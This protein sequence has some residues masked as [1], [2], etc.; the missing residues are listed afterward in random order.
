MKPHPNV[1]SPVHV[2]DV[3]VEVEIEASP[4]VVWKALTADIGRWW[5]E[6]FYCGGGSA[7]GRMLLEESPGGRL[8]EDHG[9]GDGLLWGV[10]VNR[11]RF[12]LLEL[13]GSGWGPVTALM[14]F[15]FEATPRGTRLRFTEAA[16]GRLDEAGLECKEQG[17]RF[18][19][20]CLQAH[21]H[22]Q[23]APQ[24]SAGAS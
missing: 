22:G 16:F 6:S 17:W 9:A 20:D 19:L 21:V 5:P 4:Q 10:V 8:W 14:R 2:A 18:L 13:C 7:P 3:V 11:R 23:P 1:L 15:A 24:W 12:E